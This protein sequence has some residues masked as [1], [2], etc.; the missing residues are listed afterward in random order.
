ML[1][2][3]VGTEGDRDGTPYF[4]PLASLAFD[5]TLGGDETGQWVA[6][7]TFGPSPA[8]WRRTLRA[9]LPLP[10][11]APRASAAKLEH[12]EEQLAVLQRTPERAS[13]KTPDPV[14]DLTNLG[15]FPRSRGLWNGLRRGMSWANVV[16]PVEVIFRSYLVRRQDRQERNFQRTYLALQWLLD[17]AFTGESET[18]PGWLATI[19]DLR[20]HLL[21]N[22]SFFGRWLDRADA[23]EVVS[24]YE[25]VVRHRLGKTSSWLQSAANEHHLRYEP[26]YR[27]TQNGAAFPMGGVLY[28]DPRLEA[29]P[30]P[31]WWGVANPFDLPYNPHVHPKVQRLARTHPDELIPLAIYTFQTNLALRPIIA[32]DFFAPRNPRA[33]ESTQQSMVLLKQW[34]GASTGWLSVERISYRVVAWAA[35]KKGYTLLVDKSSRLGIEE[36]RLALEADLYFDPEWRSLL[37]QRADQRVLNPLIKPAGVEE[38]LAHIQYE[39]LRAFDARAVCRRVNRVREKMMDRLGVPEKLSPAGRRQE[40]ARHLRAWHHQLSLEDYVSQPGDQLGSLNLLERPLRYFLDTQAPPSAAREELLGELYA[41]LYRQRLRLP[42]GRTLPE[43]EATLALTRRAWKQAVPEGETA[44]FERRVAKVERKSRGRLERARRKEEKQRIKVVREFFEASHKQLA[45]ARRA[46][47][48]RRTASSA[49]LEA[50]L[51]LLLEVTQ[52]ARSEEKL[53]VELQ[54]HARRLQRDLEGLEAALNHCPAQPSDP[55]RLDSRESCR[56][57]ARALQRE[58]SA[59]MN[60]VSAGGG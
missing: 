37:L 15:R 8:G 10:V 20:F 12:L 58:L 5:R 40:L 14:I 2:L 50:H 55:W 29:V 38:R 48:Q 28:Y 42:P 49:E 24:N 22:R 44:A 45:R 1:L 6:L 56:E 26:V 11:G 21:R 23:L 32:I 16:N 3:T 57:L 9:L 46:A 53:R 34:L 31:G 60:A 30:D 25:S 18:D 59:R 52:V 36:L 47:C 19:N 4:H 39:S 13:L 17:L 54:R 27:Y 43:L 33:R 7:W 51:A 41:K 35:N